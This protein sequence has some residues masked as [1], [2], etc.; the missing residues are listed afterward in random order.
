MRGGVADVINC[1][2]LKITQKVLVLADPQN[3]VS[4]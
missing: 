4:Y 3:G 1:A 2:F